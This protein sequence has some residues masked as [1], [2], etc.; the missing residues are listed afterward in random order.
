MRLLFKA[1]LAKDPKKR[2]TVKK[3]LH[4]TVLKPARKRLDA[5]INY[6]KKVQGQITEFLSATK[7][8]ENKDRKM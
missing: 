2:P 5:R 6:S 4:A 8:K 1:L 7:Q 3:A